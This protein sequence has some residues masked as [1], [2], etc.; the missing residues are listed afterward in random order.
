MI[1][2]IPE[3]NGRQTPELGC[4]YLSLAAGVEHWI[5]SGS[6]SGCIKEN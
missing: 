1:L 6:Y 4:I 5:Y 3:G 2:F